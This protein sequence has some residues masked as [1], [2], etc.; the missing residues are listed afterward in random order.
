MA[1]A[2]PLALI[3]MV[4]SAGSAVAQTAS[5]EPAGGAAAGARAPV[6]EE[7]ERL[8]QEYD[9]DLILGDDAREQFS[10]HRLNYAAVG[11]DD[12]KMQLSFKYR[13]LEQIPAFVSFTNIVAWDVY[14][15]K[16]PARDAIYNPEFFYRWRMETPMPLL[17]DAG[18]WHASNGRGDEPEKRSLDRVFVR[19]LMDFEVFDRPLLLTPTGYMTVAESKYSP[20]IADYYGN[21]EIGLVWKN[22]LDPKT[23]GSDLDLMI[24]LVDPIW[25]EGSY[26]LGLQ[27]RLEDYLWS[28]NLYVQYFRGYGDT[29]LEYDRHKTELRFG[30][31]FYY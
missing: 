14:E 2:H 7:E 25:G 24:D 27:L 22:L 16:D 18:Y 8:D 15:P 31:T 28:P 4:A 20:D 26:T 21:F 11:N 6:L 30:M 10:L 13:F 17:F 1:P 3:V 5:V 12:L 29:L 23:T 9:R 19:G